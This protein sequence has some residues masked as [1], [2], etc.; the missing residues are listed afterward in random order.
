MAT[1]CERSRYT[2]SSTK[3]STASGAF[4]SFSR[5]AMAGA[6]MAGCLV[7]TVQP[8]SMMMTKDTA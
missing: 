6:V 2:T 7:A 1:A 3:F 8:I 4:M 5:A